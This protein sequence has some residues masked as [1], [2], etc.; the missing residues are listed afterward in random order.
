MGIRLREWDV[1][2]LN[3]RL[4]QDGFATLGD[5]VKAY[6]TGIFGNKQLV[7]PLAEE[8]SGQIVN[9]ESVAQR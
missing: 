6:S 2:A 1:A 4:K 7:Q 8:I 3:M 5:M 9:I